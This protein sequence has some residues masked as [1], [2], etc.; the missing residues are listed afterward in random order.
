MS[1]KVLAIETIPRIEEGSGKQINEVYVTLQVFDSRGNCVASPRV[2]RE[3]AP[4]GIQVGDFVD[5]VKA[6]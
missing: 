1:I 3:D 4:E 5:L 2:P 6:G